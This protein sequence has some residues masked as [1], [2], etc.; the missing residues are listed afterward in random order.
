MDRLLRLSRPIDARSIV[1][2]GDVTPIMTVLAEH[3]LDGN[4]AIIS[5]S[6]QA[7]IARPLV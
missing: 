4:R 5:S 6:D 2:Y 3:Q 7:V 1:E